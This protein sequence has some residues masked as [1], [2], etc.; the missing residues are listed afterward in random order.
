MRDILLYME[1]Q[2]YQVEILPTELYEPL[3]VYSHDEIDY[4]ILKMQ[5]AGL[6]SADIQ[7]YLDGSLDIL[8]HD[9]TY[10]GH[11]FLANIHS[12][13]VWNKTKDVLSQVGSTSVSSIT[14]VAN[15]VIT[16][17]IKNLLGL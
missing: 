3:S 16:A 10:N 5:E 6:V 12:E 7:K 17:L 2:P 11:Q 14:F 13:N 4:A 9:I 8:L 1:K 15:Q